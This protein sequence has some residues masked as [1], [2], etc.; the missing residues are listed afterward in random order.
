[1]AKQSQHDQGEARV[2]AKS[3]PMMSLIARASSNVSSSTSVS[4]RRE[5][6]EIKIPGAQLQRKRKDRGN[7]VGSDRKTAF[8]C[9]YHEQLME[10]FLSK[11]FKVG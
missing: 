2:T 3:R 9:H 10:F 7:D 8:D 1:M 4:R 6:M 11:L 5:A